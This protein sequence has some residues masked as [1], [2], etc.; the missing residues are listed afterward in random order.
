ML[1]VI[2]SDEFLNH[3][4][5]LFHP[6]RPERLTAIVNAL[7]ILVLERT[8]TMAKADSG[9]RSPGLFN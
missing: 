7:K 2:Y 8:V 1:T 6:E 9:G 4:T 3:K 5:G